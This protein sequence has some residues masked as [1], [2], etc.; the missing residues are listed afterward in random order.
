MSWNI[1]CA[2]ILCALSVSLVASAS[3]SE[4]NLTV[5]FLNIGQG[6]SIFIESPQGTQILIDGGAGRAVLSELPRLMSWTDRSLDFVIGTHPDE[7]HIGGL[8]GV[9]EAYDVGAYGEPYHVPEKKTDVVLHTILEERE[10]P[11]VHLYRGQRMIV[12]DMISLDILH[13][14]NGGDGN[15]DSVTI[16]L[17]YG[18]TSYLLT[19]DIGKTTEQELIRLYGDYLDIDVLKVGHHG[20]KSSSSEEFLRITQPELAIIQ[21]GI[22]N[23]YGHPYEGVIN[24]M[25]NL[26]IPV[27]GTGTEGTIV[28]SSNG[29]TLLELEFIK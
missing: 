10:I 23:R 13:P 7:D 11:I 6:D 22:D 16:L 4:E 19:G 3:V 2:G 24:T 9:L 5:A 1:I 29:I 20:S 25:K 12:D 26:K 21:Y 17:G 8:I 27:L 28:T 18:E 15:E 14:L